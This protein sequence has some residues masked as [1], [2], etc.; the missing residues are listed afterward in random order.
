MKQNSYILAYPRA[1]VRL[2]GLGKLKKKSNDVIGT[3]TR[4]IP[5]CSGSVVR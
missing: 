1:I 5:A 3:R 4:D 2:K